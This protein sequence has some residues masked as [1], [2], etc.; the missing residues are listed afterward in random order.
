MPNNDLVQTHID[1]KVGFV[2]LNQ[3]AR[4]NAL[5]LALLRAMNSTLQHLNDHPNVHVIVLSASGKMFSMGADLGEMAQLGDLEHIKAMDYLTHDLEFISSIRKPIIAAIKGY[6]LGGGL[7]LALMCDIIVAADNVRLGLPEIKSGLMPGGG[8]TQRLTK[9][10]GWYRAM[11][12]MLTGRVIRAIEAEQ[13]GLLN[14]VVT[15]DELLPY[16]TKLASTIAQYDRTAITS[17][18]QSVKNSSNLPLE[19]GLRAERDLFHVLLGK[20]NESRAT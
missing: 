9:H 5:S 16:A 3:P 20:Y 7:E 12:L 18:K 1:G 14:A 17:I 2:A 13:L 10:I 8:A 11:E 4:K 6:T 19:Q 15:E